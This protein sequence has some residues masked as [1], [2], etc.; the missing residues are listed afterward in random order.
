[1]GAMGG[2]GLKK[3]KEGRMEADSMNNRLKNLSP[4]KSRGGLGTS[5]L[6]GTKKFH[7]GG[8]KDES[9]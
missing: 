5:G 2:R 3:K 7:E 9:T 4:K 8:S 1:L 6:K